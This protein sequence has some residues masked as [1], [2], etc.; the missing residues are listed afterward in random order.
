MEGNY[1]TIEAAKFI[2]LKRSD[3]PAGDLFIIEGIACLIASGFQPGIALLRLN[4]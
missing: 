1:M 2:N 3:F 4:N